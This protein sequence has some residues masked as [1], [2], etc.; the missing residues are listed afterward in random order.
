[1]EPLSLQLISGVFSFLKSSCGNLSAK[2]SYQFSSHPCTLMPLLP[3]QALDYRLPKR[4]LKNWHCASSSSTTIFK[5]STQFK[6]STVSHYCT[7]IHLYY[8]TNHTRITKI[9]ISAPCLFCEIL[10]IRD[11]VLIIQM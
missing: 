8:F 9:C 5:P 11:N 1:M 3:E 4:M 6:L 2:N 7:I 10:Q